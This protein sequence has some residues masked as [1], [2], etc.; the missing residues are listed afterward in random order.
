MDPG[1]GHAGRGL[2]SEAALPLG[3]RYNSQESH[4]D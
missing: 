3:S 1:R 4:H 2:L